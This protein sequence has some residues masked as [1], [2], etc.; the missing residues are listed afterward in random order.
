M[1]SREASAI[2]GVSKTARTIAA[3]NAN[4]SPTHQI[5]V[6]FDELHL[7]DGRKI[8]LHTVVSPAS[9]V[10]Q[11][12]PAG[13]KE[14]QGM[15]NAGKNMASRK[16]NEAKQ[17]ARRR[18]GQRKATDS[19]TWQSASSGETRDGAI[20]VSSAVHGFGDGL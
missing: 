11:F 6:E 14:K 10:L 15:K 13:E 3:M 16:I 4:F 2:E 7:A 8:P 19:R 9:G 17:E 1:R 18:V 5:R 12:V 20:A